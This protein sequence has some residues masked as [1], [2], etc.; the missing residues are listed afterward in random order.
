M[1]ICWIIVLEVIAIFA[2]NQINQI[3]QALI[4]ILKTGHA[5]TNKDT[6]GNTYMSPDGLQENPL[7]WAFRQSRA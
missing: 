2:V 3:G 5:G 1:A 7:D 6:Y 4:T